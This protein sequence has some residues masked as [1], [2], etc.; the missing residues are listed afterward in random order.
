[1][2]HARYKLFTIPPCLPHTFPRSNVTNNHVKA[3]SYKYVQPLTISARWNLA[4]KC[5][6]NLKVRTGDTT[7][8]LPKQWLH[9][10]LKLCWL[11]HIQYLLQFTQEHH[12]IMPQ[13]TQLLQRDCA[14]CYASKYA[15]CFTS[16]GSYKGFKQQKV[17]F[18][19][20]CNGAISHTISY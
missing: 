1:M 13:E 19:V 16:Y 8:Q 3:F 7:C 20:I 4:E 14:M 11:N 9:H 2:K 17:T 5:S 10:L 12:L 18:K 15:L 6:M